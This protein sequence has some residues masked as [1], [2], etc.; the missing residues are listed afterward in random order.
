AVGARKLEAGGKRL[1]VGVD[2]GKDRQQHVASA[3][4]LSPARATD[5]MDVKGLRRRPDYAGFHPAMKTPPLEAPCRFA[6][7]SP[8][9]R[10]CE[11]P[12]QQRHHRIDARRQPRIAPLLGM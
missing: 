12:E 8:L 7:G 6:K 3:P 5:L 9:T 2:V 11:A 10:R 4:M 1:P